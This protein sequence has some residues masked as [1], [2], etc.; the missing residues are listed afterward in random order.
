M[1]NYIKEF[2][3][4]KHHCK[5]EVELNYREKKIS[6][7]LTVYFHSIAS[8]IDG[9]LHE[10]SQCLTGK[11]II[12]HSKI[13]EIKARYLIERGEC[14]LSAEMLDLGFKQIK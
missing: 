4:G 3:V 14:V 10:R 13:L 12:M 9:E 8:Y 1:V 2:T 11:Q 7:R 5:I 6:D